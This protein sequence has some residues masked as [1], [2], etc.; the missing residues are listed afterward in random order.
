MVD[1]DKE[2]VFAFFSLLGT[3][4]ASDETYLPEVIAMAEGVMSRL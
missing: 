4:H 2:A 1:P 3:S